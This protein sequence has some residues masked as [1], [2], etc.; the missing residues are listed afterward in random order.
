MLRA[1]AL[2]PF[3]RELQRFGT[4]SHPT[5]PVACYVASC[6]LPR[7]DLHRQAN[8]VFQD[9]PQIRTSGFAAYGSCLR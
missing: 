1:V 4:A 7:P 2:L 6:Q 9:T 5:A 3:L 8:D